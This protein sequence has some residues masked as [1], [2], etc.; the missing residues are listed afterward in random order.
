MK[1]ILASFTTF[2]LSLTACLFYLDGHAQGP[3]DAIRQ[4]EKR[5]FDAQVAKDTKVMDEIL[6]DDLVYTH[7]NGLQDGKKSYIAAIESGK[8]TYQFIEISSDTVRFYGPGTAIVTGQMKTSV[9]S[10]GQTNPLRLRYTDVY[11]RRNG[12]WKMV[13]WQSARLAN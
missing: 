8:S 5:R 6:A 2:L 10:N 7:S 4:L 12:T 11:L 13:A 1:T 9:V 3:A